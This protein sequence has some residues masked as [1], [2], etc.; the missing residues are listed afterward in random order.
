[1][2]EIN[3]TLDILPEKIKPFAFKELDMSLKV[4]TKE[5]GRYWLEC[6]FDVPTP[7]SLAPDKELQNGKVLIGI[8]DKENPREKKVKICA[9]NDVY[10]DTYKIR[11]TLFVYDSDGAIAE[12]KEYAKELE[13]GE[14]DAKVLQNQ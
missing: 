8:L 11:A 3:A 12:R 9:A 5:E 7:L 1:M 6:I 10:P 4:D 14:A 2:P 13:C